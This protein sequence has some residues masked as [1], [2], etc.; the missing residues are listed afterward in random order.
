MEKYN[1]LIYKIQEVAPKLTDTEYISVLKAV[2]PGVIR[3]LNSRPNYQVL[4]D[5]L[6][7]LQDMFEHLEQ[8]VSGRRYQS[9]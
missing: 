4:V 8:Y 2:K 6:D 7:Y 3:I 9:T 5:E 1:D